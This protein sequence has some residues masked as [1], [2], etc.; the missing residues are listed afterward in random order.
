MKCS[1]A[2]ALD[3]VRLL[4]LTNNAV[5]HAMEVELPATDDMTE[6]RENFLRVLGVLPER[7]DQRWVFN[8]LGIARDERA[9][10]IMR[11]LLMDD[12]FDNVRFVQRALSKM[13]AEQP[14]FML[15]T[16]LQCSRADLSVALRAANTRMGLGMTISGLVFSGQ[17]QPPL[18]DP[19][20][21]RGSLIWNPDGADAGFCTD[22]ECANVAM[23][24]RDERWLSDL[25]ARLRRV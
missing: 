9:L 25:E 13:Q 1:R 23:V 5:G 11:V 10:G 3:R 20:L 14:P 19:Q 6:S 2:A 18:Q 12:R 21:E 16:S 17:N 7:A 22:Y 8:L 24:S 15:D 4:C